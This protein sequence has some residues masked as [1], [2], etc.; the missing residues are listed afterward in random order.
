MFSS[1]GSTKCDK[2]PG[3]Y[4]GIKEK[5]ISLEDGCI[6]CSQ[7]KY[8]ND[9]GE[10]F[11]YIMK[12]FNF[13]LILF[14]I[15]GHTSCIE[16]NIIGYYCG[17]GFIKEELCNSSVYCTGNEK[18]LRPVKPIN[19]IAKKLENRNSLKVSWE[20]EWK[21]IPSGKFEVLY[22]TNKDIEMNEMKKIIISSKSVSS[23]S[24]SSKDLYQVEINNLRVGTKY[25]TRVILSQ[26]NGAES[27][28]SELSEGIESPCPIGG[29]C[30]EPGGNGVLINE[31]KNLKGYY[32][33]KN[34]TFIL[35][36]VESNCPGIE[37]DQ[38]G[39]ATTTN[40]TVNGCPK[41][42]YKYINILIC[43]LLLMIKFRLSWFNVFKM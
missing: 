7:G 43:I 31:T 42:I 21:T 30:G 33:T 36:E 38:H 6:K 34:M 39:L 4:K 40:H 17:E 20:V 2:C 5:A 25:Y 35:C 28:P 11:S 37:L 32:Q 29:Y 14:L 19:V 26:D 27:Q 22:S 3:G 8:S 23:R 9:E 24:L 15:G 13:I 10:I 41:G 1:L 18:L 12:Y 16:C